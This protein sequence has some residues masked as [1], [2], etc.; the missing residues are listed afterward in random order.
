MPSSS[1][2]IEKLEKTHHYKTFL[3]LALAGIGLM[4]LTIV[5][6]LLFNIHQNSIS[7]H[8]LPKAFAISTVLLITCSYFLLPILQHAKDEFIGY[9]RSILLKLIVLGS[10][11]ILFQG[12]GW[13]ELIAHGI[14]FTSKVPVTLLYVLS[15]L[16]ALHFIGGFI[17]AIVLYTQVRKAMKDPVKQLIWQTN[18]FQKLKLELLVI[19]WHFM[20]LLW[21]V[22]F[23]IFF[24]SF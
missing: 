13:C 5:C 16:H 8:F 6:V 19:Y 21:V 20:D 15:G 11:F 14:T 3:Y 2:I 17:Y 7:I 12:I 1:H 23:L 24:L 18:P 22:L 4:F 10:L 9:V